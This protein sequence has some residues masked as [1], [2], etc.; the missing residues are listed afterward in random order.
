MAI[1]F[2]ALPGTAWADQ[3]NLHAEAVCQKGANIAL[4]RFA[5]AWNEDPPAYRHLPASLDGGLSAARPSR[6]EECTMANGWAIRV[7]SGEKQAYAYGMGGGDPPAFFSLW[8]ARH[9][10]LSRKEWKPGYGDDTNPWTIAVVIRPDRLTSCRVA[11]GRD[12]PE[13]GK[14]NC[15]DQPLQLDRYKVD[16][17]EYASPENKLP[18]GTMLVMPG[19]PEP[20]V[21]QEFLRL[22]RNDWPEVYAMVDSAKIF[23]TNS[24]RATPPL[25]EAII[26]VAP[27]I[28]RKLISWSSDNHYF[29]GDLIFVAPVSANTEAVLKP[30]LLEDSERFP[31]EKLPVE[32]HLISGQQP[33][34]YPDV[35]WRYVHF[36][37][38]KINGRVYV[39]AQPTNFEHEPTAILVEPI[40][41]GHRTV[42]RFKQVEPNF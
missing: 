6:R 35:S 11:Q 40:A 41:T 25:A 16:Q 12:A 8:I 33:G 5:P 9:K 2:L 3:V 36:D 4:V 39:L 20:K 29:D 26:E 13:K 28:Q 19:S 42:C 17:V 27:G 31:T 24:A 7:R 23:G 22:H 18:V 37:T 30:D 10:V 1:G 15:S 32:W 21:C 34:L 38:Q 14:I